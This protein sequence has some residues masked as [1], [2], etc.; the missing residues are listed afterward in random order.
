M[1]APELVGTSRA[2]V[3]IEE[4]LA[5]GHVMGALKEKILNPQMFLPVTDVVSRVSDDGK[6]TYREMTVNM[7]SGASMRMIENIYHNNVDV[8][9]FCVCGDNDEH[10]NLIHTDATG[11]RHLQFFKRNTST[12]EPVH[13]PAPMA[14][15]IGGIQKTLDRARALAAGSTPA[16]M[17]PSELSA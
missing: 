3:A 2:S 16:A 13:W 8:V 12:L 17:P 6:G 5:S 15:A 7:P 10:V 14:I 1:S 11:G 4:S 9:R